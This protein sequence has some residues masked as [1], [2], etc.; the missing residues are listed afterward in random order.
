MNVIIQRIIGLVLGGLVVATGLYVAGQSG[1]H[2]YNEAHN[3]QIQDYIVGDS[4]N[5]FTDYFDVVGSSLVFYAREA[6]F[7]PRLDVHQLTRV[8]SFFFQSTPLMGTVDATGSGGVHLQSNV[9]YQVEA[10]TTEDGATTFATNL[11][12]QNG[13]GVVTDYS[14]A[15]YALFGFGALTIL[16]AL[17]MR[18]RKGEKPG[19]IG[20]MLGLWAL[21]AGLIGTAAGV[22]FFLKMFGMSGLPSSLDGLGVVGAVFLLIP[23]VG[24]VVVG[25]LVFRGIIS[26]DNVE[27]IDF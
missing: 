1:F 7:T 13:R 22:L 15:E 18:A 6:D 5:G 16:L 20:R 21:V 26:W 19:L 8:V 17:F 12:R 4:S 27:V 10:I 25:W 14:Y 23:S 9:G 2:P 3:V 11:Y 24:F